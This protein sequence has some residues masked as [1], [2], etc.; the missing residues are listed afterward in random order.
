[1]AGS[2]TG[3][4]IEGRRRAAPATVCLSTTYA[5]P[6]SPIH[7]VGGRR[8]SSWTWTIWR[9]PWSRSRALHAE[10][11]SDALGHRLRMALAQEHEAEDQAQR[12]HGEDGQLDH[13]VLELHVA[14]LGHLGQLRREDE[15]AAD[16]G[17]EGDEHEGLGDEDVLAEGELHSVEQLDD[18]QDQQDLIEYHDHASR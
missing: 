2:F 5:C 13:G 17:D 8:S 16:T 7:R 3:T 12:H 14:L 9:H 18:H 6:C 15:D 11:L 1:C 10:P 4:R